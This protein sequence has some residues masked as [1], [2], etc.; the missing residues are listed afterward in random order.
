MEIS[1]FSQ[2]VYVVDIVIIAETMLG[3]MNNSG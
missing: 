3:F 2:S 1:Y